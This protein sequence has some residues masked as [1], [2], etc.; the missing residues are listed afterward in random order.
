MKLLHPWMKLFLLRAMLIHLPQGVCVRVWCMVY[1]AWCMV[2]GC[3]VYGVWHMGVLFVWCVRM[4]HLCLLYGV[5]VCVWVCCVVWAMSGGSLSSF[6]GGRFILGIGSGGIYRGSTRRQFGL[7]NVSTLDTMRDYLTIV[8]GLVAG[9]RVSHDGP[10]VRLRQVSLDI[11]PPP[12]TPV[13]LGALGPKMLQLGGELADGLALNWCNADQVAWSRERIAEGA[14]LAGRSPGDV[15]V[16]EYIR[17]CVDDD[18]EMAK[19]ALASTTLGYAL[20]QS[21]EI[22]KQTRLGYRGHFERMGFG[23]M[24]LEMENMQNKGAAHEDLADSFPDEQLHQVGY[25]G[26]AEGVLPA[27]KRLSKGLDLAIVRVVAARPGVE[28]VINTM[29]ACKPDQGDVISW[30]S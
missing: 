15:K 10:A 5:Y 12:R 26:R 8:R 27:L 4:V 9:D 19:R 11:D 16:A 7:K 6:T 2:Y 28:S 18:V 20:G 17:V 22:G 24:L 23:D 13:F 21:R 30:N 14:R 29:R 3:V 1:G 25:F